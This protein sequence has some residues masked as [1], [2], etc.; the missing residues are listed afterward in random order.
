MEHSGLNIQGIE[1]VAPFFQLVQHRCRRLL[2][3]LF[4]RS[5]QVEMRLGKT[6]A[7]IVAVFSEF[8]PNFF[9]LA[10]K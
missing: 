3:G 6:E 9:R 10:A 4:E 5:V 8:R 7:E 1:E 2:V